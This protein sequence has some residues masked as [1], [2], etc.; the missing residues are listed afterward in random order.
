M[1]GH[2]IRFSST[3]QARPYQINIT[4]SAYCSSFIPF[5]LRGREPP[6][7]EESF[8]EGNSPPAPDAWAIR[9][10]SEAVAGTGTA[11]TNLH[12]LSKKRTLCLPMEEGEAVERDE[13]ETKS[14]RN[15]G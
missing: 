7:S 6:P 5:P 11:A 1:E 4:A 12:D 8:A 10:Y 9:S 2:S 15:G 13:Y 14:T 3:D